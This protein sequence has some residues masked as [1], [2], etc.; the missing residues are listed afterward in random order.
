MESSVRAQGEEKHSLSSRW[1]PPA[2]LA[3]SHELLKNARPWAE[4]AGGASAWSMPIDKQDA[5]DRFSLNSG[6]FWVNYVACLALGVLLGLVVHPASALALLWMV[7]LAAG[8][9]AACAMA[10][11]PPRLSPAQRAAAAVGTALVVLFVLTDAGTVI[12]T[13]AALAA[14]A[15]AGHA[16]CRA[17]VVDF[18]M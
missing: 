2:A 15:C 11:G 14:L 12:M 13:S 18:A 7:G 1:S 16:V 6:R 8:A 3:A 4:F 17:P 5:A 9:E 10:G